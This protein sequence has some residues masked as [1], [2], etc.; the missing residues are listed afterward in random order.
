LS[1]AWLTEPDERGFLRPLLVTA[2]EVVQVREGGTPTR[3]ALSDPLAPEHPT[4]V[5]RL[6]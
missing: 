6:N 3:F 2:D 1:A 5:Q 4:P